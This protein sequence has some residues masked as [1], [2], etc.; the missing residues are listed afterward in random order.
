[1]L[2]AFSSKTK[3]QISNWN[4]VSKAGKH[5]RRSLVQLTC[6][7]E[8]DTDREIQTQRVYERSECAVLGL[9]FVPRGILG[10]RNF[11]PAYAG[12]NGFPLKRARGTQIE[13]SPIAGV[14]ACTEFAFLPLCCSGVVRLARI[15]SGVVARYPD[16]DGSCNFQGT[17]IKN[18]KPVVRLQILSKYK[19]NRPARDQ[20]ILSGISGGKMVRRSCGAA[21]KNY[22][23]LFR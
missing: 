11:C 18:C 9:N 7:D 2:I 4:S 21:G 14:A 19:E 1:M 10:G 12:R 6:A 17:D 20:R 23:A 16:P 13:V 3:I 8:R 5:F 22:S 15:L